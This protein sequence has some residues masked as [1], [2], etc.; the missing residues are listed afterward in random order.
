MDVAV[1]AIR[2]RQRDT[3]RPAYYPTGAVTQPVTAAK[4]YGVKR[5][6]YALA[7]IHLPSTAAPAGRLRQYRQ[8]V[9]LSALNSALRPARVCWFV[10]RITTTKKSRSSADVGAAPPHKIIRSMNGRNSFG[11][12]RSSTYPDAYGY[13]DLHWL[14]NLGM[15]DTTPGYIRRFIIAVNS[16]KVYNLAGW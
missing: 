16:G 13:S 15:D 5:F 2:P 14:N 10:R 7:H 4:G 1:C 3:A 11:A 6:R 8:R 12:R 9:G